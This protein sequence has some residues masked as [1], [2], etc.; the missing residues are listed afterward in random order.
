MLESDIQKLIQ[1]K[2]AQCGAKLFRN[3]VGLGWIGPTKR[4]SDGSI[5]MENPR[6]LHAGLQKGSGDLIGFKPT[7]ITSDMVGKMVAVFVS[8]EV[9]TPTGRVRPEQLDWYELVRKN[10]GIAG[11]ARSEADVDLLFNQKKMEI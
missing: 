2:S 11:F 10:G 5:L 8:L 3:N 4:L 6:P 9:K 1:L 7:V